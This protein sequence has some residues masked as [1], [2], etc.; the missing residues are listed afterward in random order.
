MVNY[1]EINAKQ[2]VSEHDPFTIE[3]YQQF[4]R[5]LSPDV[6]TVLDIGC[7]T[8]RGGRAFKRIHP[9]LK[10]IGLDCVQ[11]RIDILPA[12]VYS[13]G[14]CSYST[15]IRI[16]NASVDAILAGEFV[17]HLDYGDVD[18]TFREFHRVLIPGGTLIL[19]TPN[20]DYIRLKITGGSVIGDAHMSQHYPDDLVKRLERLG[21]E[22]LL[23]RGSGKL[24]RLLGE[25]WPLLS[26]YGS[27]LVKAVRVG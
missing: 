7:N 18:I 23:I 12:D 9:N 13:S 4:A 2:T 26:F 10:L 5:Y 15:K 27:Y 21:F 11:S 25:C 24:T 19:T 14:V 22:S 8:G 6:T 20:P 17:E 1:V 16:P 3:R